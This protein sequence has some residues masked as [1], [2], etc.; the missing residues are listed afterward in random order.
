MNHIKRKRSVV[1]ALIVVA[2]GCFLLVTVLNASPSTR[3]AQACQKRQVIA[4][5][6]SSGGNHWTVTG[7][8]RD[9]RGSCESWLFGL[10]FSPNRKRGSFSWEWGIP[11]GGSLPDSFT[12]SARDEY[13]GSERVFA[14]AAG[15]RV[16]SIVLTLDNGKQMKVSPLLPAPELRK[17]FVWLRNVRYFVRYYPLES[18]V[19]VVTVRDAKG[20][21]AR[22]NGVEGAF[23]TH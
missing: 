8:I 2:A 20:I 5:G 12:I 21:I 4:K 22:V 16:V 23:V 7:W 11:A 3:Q 15:A 13:E 1:Y 18:H 14:G 10:G 9:N 17:R 6:K 19:R